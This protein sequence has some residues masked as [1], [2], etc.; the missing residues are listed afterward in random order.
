MCSNINIAWA[1]GGVSLHCI[2]EKLQQQ[3]ID[4]LPLPR[5][6]GKPHIVIS[7]TEELLLQTLQPWKGIKKRTKRMIVRLRALF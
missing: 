6:V 5:L 4:S 3:Q 7:A 2:A 1:V